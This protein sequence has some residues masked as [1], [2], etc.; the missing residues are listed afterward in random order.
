[1]KKNKRSESTS[2]VKTT[3]SVGLKKKC[4]KRD[5]KRTN[6]RERERESER[7]RVRALCPFLSL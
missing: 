2:T 7:S 6:E 1:M 4:R 3:Q 5:N